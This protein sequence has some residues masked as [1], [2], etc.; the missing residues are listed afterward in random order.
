MHALD[1]NLLRRDADRLAASCDE[2]DFFCAEIR[3]RLLERL[4]LVSLQPNLI[5][6][7]GAGTGAAR[8]SLQSLYP[9]ARILEL[10]WSEAMLAQSSGDGRLCADAHRLP[11]ADAGIDMVF[12]NL[13][14]QGCA[15]PERVFNEA[16]RVLKHPGLFLFTTL[17]PDTL[18]QLRRAWSRVDDLP[19]VH[20]FADMHNIGDAL[21]QAGFRDPVMDVE[22]LTITYGHAERLIAD[23]R[24]AGATNR[25]LE[26]RRG[27]T[28]PRLWQAMLAELE[29]ARNAEGR[30]EITVELITGQ[31]WTGEA[32][33]GVQM[34]EGE[35]SFPLERLRGPRRG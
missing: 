17:G 27:L 8:A 12:S 7:L 13:M 33:R 20:A 25:L 22:N 18:K 26:R 34:H 2:Q 31:A 10:D 29:A 14:L 32:A 15:E 24:Q 5:L 21:V 9:D 35:A 30:L 16:R 23:L 3:D 19:H 1:Q 11:L 6:E 4:A 28:P